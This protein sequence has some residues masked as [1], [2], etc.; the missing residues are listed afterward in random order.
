M[1]FLGLSVTRNFTITVTDGNDP[2]TAINASGVL[3]FT[4]N[5]AAGDYVGTLV[6]TDQDVRQTHQYQII[7]VVAEGHGRKR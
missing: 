7:S 1:L 4:E 2:P 6:T 3:T 5:N